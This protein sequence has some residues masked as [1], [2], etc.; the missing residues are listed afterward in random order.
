[1]SE[2]SCYSI[3]EAK[4]TQAGGSYPVPAGCHSLA[5]E[6]GASSRT[7]GSVSRKT[8]MQVQIQY[9]YKKQKSRVASPTFFVRNV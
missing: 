3:V 9:Y 5:G 6:F 4:G 8:E 7:E 1:M 2:K